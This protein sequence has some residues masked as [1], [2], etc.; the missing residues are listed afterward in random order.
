MTA[1]HSSKASQPSD[2]M[3]QSPAPQNFA[4]LQVVPI[5][6]Y[7]FDNAVHHGEIEVH[8]EAVGDIQAFFRLAFELKFPIDKVVKADDSRYRSDDE[9]L[10]AD[11][12]TSGFNYRF[13]ADSDRLS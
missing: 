4:E 10:M 6:Y 7:G 11:N 8:D 5:D 13:V 1:G 2:S 12:A 3:E 9:R